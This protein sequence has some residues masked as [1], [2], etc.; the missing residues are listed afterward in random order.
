MAERATPVWAELIG[1][2]V[3]GRVALGT[4]RLDAACGLLGPVADALRSSDD[5]NGWAYWCQLL[6]S[7]ALAMRGFT[8]EAA[9]ALTWLEARRH[10]GWRYLDHELAVAQAWL[11]ASQVRSVRRSGRRC[12]R[13]KPPGPM[14]NS[15]RK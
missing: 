9:A 10:P 11:S 5:T 13:R 4:G 1:L 7:T 3:L 12:R 14:A 8:D 2:V 15:R 6:Y